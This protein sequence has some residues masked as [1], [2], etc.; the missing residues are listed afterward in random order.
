MHNNYL[1]YLNKSRLHSIFE[2]VRIISTGG[3]V[4][5]LKLDLSR[6]CRSPRNM[7]EAHRPIRIICHVPSRVGPCWSGSKRKCTATWC[8]APED[9]RK[10]PK[11]GLYFPGGDSPKLLGLGIKVDGLSIF[12]RHCFAHFSLSCHLHLILTKER[13]KAQN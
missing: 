2:S 6:V 8:L 10:S 1:D 5:I 11:G 9:R 13:K 3:W 12:L 4:Q 7:L